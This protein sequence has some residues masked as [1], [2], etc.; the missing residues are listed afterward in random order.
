MAGEA[1]PLFISGRI[2][3]FPQTQ[4]RS[5]NGRLQRCAVQ[6]S[7]IHP[8]EGLQVRRLFSDAFPLFIM[9]IVTLLTLFRTD[10]HLFDFGNPIGRW[11]LGR[12]L[13]K[14]HSAIQAHEAPRQHHS[15]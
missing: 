15:N 3:L 5:K 1:S 4:H 2:R 10:E 9:T 12:C 11:S 13:S 6:K 7:R 8:A 14:G